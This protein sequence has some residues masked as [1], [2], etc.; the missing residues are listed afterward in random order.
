MDHRIV[1]TSLLPLLAVCHIAVAACALPACTDDAPA[2]PQDYPDDTT[3]VSTD[4][5]LVYA[6]ADTLF[7]LR[8][9][10]IDE[11][12]GIAASHR[13]QLIFWMH[14]D[15]GDEPRLF[16]LDSTGRTLAV[17]MLTN[18]GNVDWEDMASVMIDGNSWLYIGDIGDNA[19]RRKDISIYRIREP[20]L[21]TAWDRHPL[22]ATA[23]R[24]RFTYEDGPRDCEALAVDPRD[25]TIILVEKSGASQPAV[26]RASWPGDGGTGVLTRAGAIDIPFAFSLLRSVTGADL[27]VQGDRMIVRCYGGILERTGGTT[28]SLSALLGPNDWA[29]LPGAALFQ[30]EAVCYT[31]DGHAVITGSEG[32]GT[33]ML[34]FLR[35]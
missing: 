10:D 13:E 18:A 19:A 24:A 35:K 7:L 21:S 25:G 9:A 3:T 11:L 34:R 23:E 1:R 14:N 29:T 28:D 22:T 6:A 16:A 27:S 30:P 4:D 20:Q 33:P 26:Y 32:I 8:D 2:Q 17:C 31:A 15:S 12:S 5:S